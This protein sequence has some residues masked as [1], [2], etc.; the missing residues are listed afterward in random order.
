MKTPAGRIFYDHFNENLFRSDT[1]IERTQL[2]S[3]LDHMGAIGKS[4]EYAAQVTRPRPPPCP[5]LPGGGRG[6]GL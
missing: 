1:G 5:A 2:G 3:L 6:R 4:E